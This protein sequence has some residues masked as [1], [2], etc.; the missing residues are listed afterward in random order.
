MPHRY[1]RLPTELLLA[2][3][4]DKRTGKSAEDIGFEHDVH[5]GTV[6]KLCAHVP[7]GTRR[8]LVKASILARAVDSTDIQTI[9]SLENCSVRFVVR[10]LRAAALE[11]EARQA[12]TERQ[13][14]PRRARPRAAKRTEPPPGSLLAR[15]APPTRAARIRAAY[16]DEHRTVEEIAR[17]HGVSVHTVQRAT[18]GVPKR[19]GGRRSDRARRE[20]IRA[21]YLAGVPIEEIA[22]EH[23]VCAGSVQYHVRDLPRRFRAD[24]RPDVRE[25]A[26]AMYVE[27]HPA[28]DIAAALG[29]RSN[30][31]TNWARGLRPHTLPISEERIEAVRA[32]YI[33][34][35]TWEEIAREHGVSEST[36]ARFTRDLPRRR[37]HRTPLD[38]AGCAAPT[39]EAACLPDESSAVT[40]TLVS[41]LP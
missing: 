37:K 31:V 34:G 6:Q 40:S 9:C 14:P 1:A 30:D 11:A 23:G 36:V 17:E 24:A 21:K 19:K 26:R 29:V 15:I 12:P 20:S 4:D 41:P 18:K 38:G 5:P 39:L 35:H 3:V 33:A 7:D 25:R 22:R 10:I 16:A 8:D 28:K 13:K 27:G 2:I 32:A